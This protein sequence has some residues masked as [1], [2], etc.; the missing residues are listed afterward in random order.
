MEEELALNCCRAVKVLATDVSKVKAPDDSFNPVP[1]RLLKDEPFRT[2]LVV[3]AVVEKRFVAVRAV[4]EAYVAIKFVV[5]SAVVDAY[6]AVR[7]GVEKA[8]V[9]EPY[10]N[11]RRPVVPFRVRALDDVVAF[12]ATVVV[13]K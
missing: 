6:V 10:V 1:R 4:L 2:K 12:P 11:D 7:F 3:E 8:R 13:E 5:D 9:D